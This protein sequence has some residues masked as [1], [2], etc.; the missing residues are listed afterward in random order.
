MKL[1][2]F[3]I[4]GTL[5]HLDGST[6]RAF[7]Y[8]FRKIFDREL[9]T[10]GLK[11][12]GRTDPLIFSE[13]FVRAGLEGDWTAAYEKF[14]P[15]YFGKLP[16]AIEKNPRTHTHP[17]VPE[18]LDALTARKD[19]CA[20]A[21]G[22][23]NA[24]LGAR[25]KIGYFDLNSYFPVGGFGDHHQVRSLIMKDA[26]RES[27]AYYDQSFDLENTWIIGD[28]VFDIEGGK[29]I[30]ARTLGV[31]TGGAYSYEDLV[32]AEPDVVLH[33]L[34]DTEAVLKELE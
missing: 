3:D 7:S 26:I 5:T 11:L 21:L 1:L 17:G 32:A 29:A 28:T 30:G 27:E 12:H 20:L 16:E 31:A 13:C 6:Y 4:D 14:K 24:E 33:D 19:R 22:T 8:A 18:L 15:I 25:A 10:E 23:G 2:I 34:S 9:I